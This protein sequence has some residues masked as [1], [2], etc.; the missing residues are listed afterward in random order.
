MSHPPG[1]WNVVILEIMLATAQLIDV[2]RAREFVPKE[3]E[4]TAPVPGKTPGGIYFARY[5]PGSSV[6]YNE[7]GVFPAYVRYAGRSG[8]WVGQMYVDNEASREFAREDL[9]LPK[10]MAE[11]Y[12]Q[13]SKVTIKQGDNLICAIEHRAPIMMPW[14]QR[15]GGGAFGILNGEVI[16]FR[17]E[18][19]TR[20]GFVRAKVTVPQD[21]P[22]AK[23]GLDHPLITG[24]GKNASGVLA[25]DIEQLG[26][27][28]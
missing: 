20:P 21:S 9:G 13:A 7:L 22:I 15:I 24:C 28:S 26:R 27:I 23:F 2:G 3:F 14:R 25:K 8:I 12:H 18:V 19:K 10:E 4:I 6:Q 17:N 16:Y 5:G 11:F 1:P